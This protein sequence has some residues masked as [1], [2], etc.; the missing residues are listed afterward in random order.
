MLDRNLHEGKRGDCPV[1][2][3]IHWAWSS[4]WHIAEAQ[5]IFWV[6]ANIYWI[7][8]FLLMKESTSKYLQLLNSIAPWKEDYDKPRQCINKQSHHFA[9]KK[10]V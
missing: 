1:P 5:F 4:D 3:D 6:V 7:I 8:V 9:D 10:Y 2:L